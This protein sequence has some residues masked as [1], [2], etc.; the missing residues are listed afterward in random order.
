[1]IEPTE[2]QCQADWV[3]DGKRI[4]GLLLHL[5]LNHS[6]GRPLHTGGGGDGF[7]FLN[8]YVCEENG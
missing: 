7:F 5:Q 4:M 8:K 2:T 1:M 3:V 6:K